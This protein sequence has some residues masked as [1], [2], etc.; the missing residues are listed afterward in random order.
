MGNAIEKNVYNFCTL[1]WQ[2]DSLYEHSVIACLLC[3]QNVEVWIFMRSIPFY[4]K[5]S[6]KCE[7]ISILKLSIYFQRLNAFKDQPYVLY[8]LWFYLFSASM[9][10]HFSRAAHEICIIWIVIRLSRYYVFPWIKHQYWCE[11]R[12]FARM[13]V[14]I[15]ADSDPLLNLC[16]PAIVWDLNSLGYIFRMMCSDGL[17]SVLN[18]NSPSVLLSIA[19]CLAYGSTSFP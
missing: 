16:L 14:M 11:F 12:V 3:T 18:P 17:T 1:C 8:A 13:Y 19:A 15:W 6:D 10:L 2:S 7:R 4:P 5:T 9:E